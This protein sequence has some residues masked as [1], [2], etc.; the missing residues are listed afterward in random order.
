MNAPTSVPTCAT[1]LLAHALHIE[2]QK[3]FM[4]VTVLHPLIVPLS[5]IWI[6]LPLLENFSKRIWKSKRE[7]KWPMNACC[8]WDGGLHSTNIKILIIR[9]KISPPKYQILK[10]GDFLRKKKFLT[11]CR[12]VHLPFH[13]LPCT[14][15][16]TTRIWILNNLLVGQV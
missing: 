3:K 7:R 9:D 12:G 8:Y 15:R 13:S 11:K 1:P 10:K 4:D 16:S 5:R 6:T 2:Y 14:S